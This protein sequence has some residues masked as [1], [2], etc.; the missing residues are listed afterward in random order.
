MSAVMITRNW[1]RIGKCM[2]SVKYYDKNKKNN[3]ME[4]LGFKSSLC[5]VTE[6][7]MKLFSLPFLAR[8]KPSELK[9][10][11]SKGE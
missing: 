8:R 4:K 1:V 3:S 10:D 11:P 5:Y 9:Q 7:G 6:S 2:K